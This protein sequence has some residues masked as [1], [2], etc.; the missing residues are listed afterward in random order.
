MD[1]NFSCVVAREP[2]SQWEGQ[3]REQAREKQKKSFLHLGGTFCS[4]N[5]DSALSA[6]EI[7]FF[8]LWVDCTFYPISEHHKAVLLDWEHA[9][10]NDQFDRTTRGRFEC[11]YRCFTWFASLTQFNSKL[12]VQEN[13]IP[14]SPNSGHCAAI[15]IQKIVWIRI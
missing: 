6:E 3:S 11:C 10:V 1:I 5:L 13:R 9:V 4:E 12:L 7:V 2:E 15:R 8:A 14:E